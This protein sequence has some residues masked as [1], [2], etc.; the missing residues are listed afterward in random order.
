[1]NWC[2]L[3]HFQTRVFT[4]EMAVGLL[5]SSW[6]AASLIWWFSRNIAYYKVLQ[7]GRLSG[8]WGLLHWPN[9]SWNDN[10]RLGKRHCGQV[11]GKRRKFKW[12]EESV[13]CFAY[14]LFIVQ[15]AKNFRMGGTSFLLSMDIIR[16]SIKSLLKNSG[17]D[18]WCLFSS[19]MFLRPEERLF[20]QKMLLF[21]MFWV[22]CLQSNINESVLPIDPLSQSVL[23]PLFFAI[24]NVDSIANLNIPS[25]FVHFPYNAIWTPLQIVFSRWFYKW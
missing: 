5:M 18:S 17:H 8:N 2:L 22:C 9:T 4:K 3:I 1:M 25:I 24:Q 14:K 11:S 12:Y 6:Q 7:L 23:S 20:M 19:K 16:S 15:L 21:P 10:P 13:Y